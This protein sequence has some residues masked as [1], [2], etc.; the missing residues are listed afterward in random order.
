M[1]RVFLLDCTLR[2]G[3][4]VNDW[5]FGRECVCDCVKTLNLSKVDII[6]LGMIRKENDNPERTV[7]S[8][9][10]DFSYVLSFK[11]E[12]TLFSAMI[13][14][15]EPELNYPVSKL[16]TPKETGID[17][18]RICTWKRLMKEHID[19]CKEIANLGYKISI[20]PT[21]IDQYSDDEFIELCKLANTFKPFS[22]YLVDTWGTQ[23]SKQIVH[24]AKLADAYLNKDIK[25]GYHG[26]NNKMQAINCVEALFNLKLNRDVCFDSSIMGM[27]RGPGNLQTEVLMD[28]LNKL[29][30]DKHYDING[31][32]H[33]Y[34]KYISKF[35]EQFGWGYSIYHFI[36]ANNALPQD[37]ATFFKEQNY[38]IEDFIVFINSLTSKEKVVFKK[39]FVE[40][41]LKELNINK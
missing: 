15:N 11:N 30:I 32:L 39:D 21:A 27:G 6:E 14:G 8:K 24:Y 26:H 16:K 17:L 33:L 25:L 2:D 20:Q 9:M 4:Y 3:G 34:S 5:R 31:P 12:N 37:F 7:F 38:S 10:E 35:Y 36:S 13:E 29:G 18:L 40:K 28:F 22:L 23:N 1:R 41:R 19:Y